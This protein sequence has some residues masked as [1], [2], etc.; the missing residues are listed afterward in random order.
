[1][2]G[3]GIQG[4]LAEPGESVCRDIQ[5]VWLFSIGAIR[6]PRHSLDQRIVWSENVTPSWTIFGKKVKE[7]VI[8]QELTGSVDCRVV[9]PRH[10]LGWVALEVDQ[11]RVKMRVWWALWA[12]GISAWSIWHA[13]MPLSEGRLCWV[14][15]CECH[16]LGNDQ[17]YETTGPPETLVIL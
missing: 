9:M 4:K 2:A 8:H 6:K 10:S 15:I 1:M 7:R 3:R 16:H 14:H 13:R 17:S 12:R 11:F 5:Y